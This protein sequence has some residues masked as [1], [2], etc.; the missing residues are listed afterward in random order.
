MGHRLGDDH[1]SRCVAI[2]GFDYMFVTDGNI[3]NRDEWVSCDEKDVD[4]S[5]VLKVLVVR[6]HEVQ[7]SFRACGYG[8]GG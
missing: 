2:V 6:G 4:Q 5:K 7:S 3:Y 1:S 8:Q